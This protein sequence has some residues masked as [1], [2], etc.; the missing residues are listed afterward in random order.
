MIQLTN[1][2]V[3]VEKLVNAMNSEDK[4]AQKAAWEQFCGSIAQRV[5]ADFEEL[6]EEQ[7]AAVLSARGYRQL[8]SQERSFYEKF[9]ETAKSGNPRQTFTDLITEEGMPTTI[10]EDVFKD[11]Q[12]EHPLLAAINFQNV[13]YLTKWLLH[14]HSE[15]LATWGAIT[16]EITKQ[17]QSSFRTLS[18]DQ[19]KLTAYCMIEKGMLEMGP[20]WLDGYVRAILKEALYCGLEAAIIDGTGS[21][22][23][24]GL[25]RDVSEGVTVTGGIYPLKTAVEVTGF[26]PREYGA[27]VA[28]LVETERGTKKTLPGVT[29]ICNQ[30]DYLTKVMPA[31]T[32]MNASGQYITNLFPFPTKVIISNRLADGTAILADLPNYFFGIGM[33]RD[34]IIEY[35]D[36]FKFLDDIRTYKIKQY[37]HGRAVDNNVAIVLDISELRAAYLPVGIAENTAV[38]LS[39]LVVIAFDSNGGTGSAAPVITQ[40]SMAQYLPGGTG[41]TAP[42]GKKFAGWANAPDDT[43]ADYDAGDAITVTANTIL[44]AIWADIIEITFDANGGTGTIAALVAESGMAQILPNYTGL[45]PPANSHFVGWATDATTTDPEDV[46]D[47]GDSITVT[48]DTTIYAIWGGN[49]D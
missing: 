39:D 2:D 43:T 22:M 11:L 48:A 34:G 25:N 42:T 47:P 9:I 5:R 12:Q 4:E 14:D 28:Q 40:K 45:T 21:Q 13:K 24:I 35:S 16:D 8:T 18:I 49:S 29:L 26:A 7:D 41:L 33:S 31:T 44:Y 15:Q 37:G 3:T 30:T 10:I 6:K 17:I 36:E 23:P 38:E 1:D 32:V 19:N 46:Y 27:L 20:T